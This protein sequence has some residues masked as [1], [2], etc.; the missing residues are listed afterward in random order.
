MI[1]FLEL[2][3]TIASRYPHLSADEQFDLA[4]ESVKIAVQDAVPFASVEICATKMREHFAYLDATRKAT[5]E[6]VSKVVE[7]LDPG[8]THAVG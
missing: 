4:L 8:A 7:K 5:R 1:E 2:R 3:D 6:M